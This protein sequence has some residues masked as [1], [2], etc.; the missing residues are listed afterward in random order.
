MK[1]VVVQ[2]IKLWPGERRKRQLPTGVAS[3]WWSTINVRLLDERISENMWQ[4]EL[5]VCSTGPDR[6]GM[7]TS[8][9]A[10]VMGRALKTRLNMDNGMY[11]NT[12]HMRK[13]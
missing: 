7:K 11:A 4:N 5:S 13:G 10:H 12:M 6:E 1:I 2:L 9:L 8:K 3:S